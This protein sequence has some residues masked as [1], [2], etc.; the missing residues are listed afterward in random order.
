MQK[1]IAIIKQNETGLTVANLQDA[2]FAM[3]K[4]GYISPM[5]AGERPTEKDLQKLAEKLKDEQAQS[6]YGE[7]TTQLVFYFQLQNGLGDSLKGQ[8][9]DEKTADMI[10]RFLAE[11]GL[12]DQPGIFT[13][14]GAVKD[15][16]DKPQPDLTVIAF[17]KD[18][19]KEQALGQSLTDAQGNYRVE[20]TA[21]DFAIAEGVADKP[22]LLVRVYSD[23][24]KTT[25][26]AESET[27]FNAGRDEVFD[28]TIV[29][30]SIS[31]WERITSAVLPL[32]ENQREDGKSLPPNELTS[33][34]ID[35]IVANTGLDREQLRLW[36]LAFS[37]ALSTLKQGSPNV[38]TAM[39][40][41]HVSP[42]HPSM[43]PTKISPIYVIFYGWF[44]D[45][46]PQNWVDLIKISVDQL[47]A[48][49]KHAV[50][51]NY[52][53]ELDEKQ[54][55]GIEAFIKQ[56]KLRQVIKP[57]TEGEP[58]S[59][60]DV[61]NT[62][63]ADW[64]K[65]KLEHI[66][67]LTTITS[68]KSEDFVEQA[69]SAGLNNAQALQLRQTLYLGEITQNNIPLMRALQPKVA[70][71]K[72]GSLKGLASLTPNDWL[73]L[74]YENGVGSI[75]LISHARYAENLQDSIEKLMPHEVLKAK[76]DADS[77]KFLPL[78]FANVKTVLA[79]HKDFDIVNS[80][81]DQ[82]AED[83]KIDSKTTSALV[84]LQHL[85]RLHASWDEVSVLVNTK[86]DDAEEITNF[87][88]DQFKDILKDHLP[89]QRLDEI[90]RQASVLKA[91]S[92]GLVGHMFPVLYG[93]SPAVMADKSLKSHKSQIDSNPTLRKIFGAL[94]QCACD[95]CLS[96]LSPA[97]YLADLLK[98]IDGSPSARTELERRRPDIFDLELSC[99]NTKIEL[100]QIDLAIEILENAIALP[101]NVVWPSH[102]DIKSELSNGKPIGNNTL[103]ALQETSKE[104]L[105]N[106]V[107]KESA[108]YSNTL[109]SPGKANWTVDDQYRT[110]SIES[111]E[112]TL[113]FKKLAQ[114]IA[115]DIKKMVNADPVSELNSG[116]I[117][118]GLEGEVGAILGDVIG[119]KLPL[120]Q[121]DIDKIEIIPL[122]PASKNNLKKWKIN[123]SLEGEIYIDLQ[124]NSLTI[125]RLDGLD[126]KKS[127]TLNLLTE[128]KADLDNNQITSLFIDYLNNITRAKK[129]KINEFRVTTKDLNLWGFK[130]SGSIGL[131]YQ[132]AEIN[133]TGLAYQST[134]ADRDLFAKPQNTNPLAYK[135]I[136]AEDA[137]FPWSLPYNQALNETRETLNAAGVTRL[138]LLES[139]TPYEKQYSSMEIAKERLG[140]STAELALITTSQL[141]INNEANDKFFKVWGL[142]A[143][144]TAQ[145]IKDT[146]SDELIEKPAFGDEGLLTQVSI[147]LQQSGLSF[148]E[149]GRLLESEFINPGALIS[150]TEASSAN[151]RPSEMRLNKT[152]EN[153]LAPFLDRLHR[154]VRLW[155]VVG[156]QIWELDLAMQAEGIGK[157][158]LDDAAI[159]QIAN[160]NLLKERLHL[161]VDVLVAMIAGFGDK[162]Y[163]QL[164]KNEIRE[165]APLYDRLF[166]NRQLFDPPNP[167]LAFAASL[168]AMDEPLTELIAAS[169]GLR[170][171]EL[172][173]MLDSNA[174]DLPR[175]ILNGT[176]AAK[177]ELLQQVFRNV[178]LAKALGLSL[179]DYESAWQLFPSNHFESPA[180]LLN[181][182]NE[183]SFVKNS[184]FE[185]GELGYLLLDSTLNPSVTALELTTERADNILTVLQDELKQLLPLES[186]ALLLEQR[187]EIVVKHLVLA[188][189]LEPSLV[190]GLI[191]NY[192][193]S[194]ETTSE[195]AMQYL[196]SDLFINSDDVNKSSAYVILER[197]YK[198]AL[199][200]RKWGSRLSEFAWTTAEMAQ[201]YV[202]AGLVFNT[203][204]LVEMT[205][206]DEVN[207][208][209]QST[210][211]FQLAHSSPE[212]TALIANY[213]NAYQS[214]VI[215][216]DKKSEALLA[217]ATSFGLSEAT[218]EACVSKLGMADDQYLDPLCFSNLIGLL[219]TVHQL[220]I[221]DISL[222]NLVT[223]TAFDASAELAGKL[224]KTRF[225]DSGWQK[226]LRK[227][228]DAL[229]LQKRDRLVDFLLARE[230]LSDSDALYKHYLIDFEMSPCMN[231]TRMLQSTAAVQLFVQR[232]LFNLEQ[233]KV[234]LNP[235]DRKRWEWAQNYRVWEAN[236][237]VFLY[238]E[239]WLFPEVRDDK[240]ETF[241]AF[242]SALAQ[243]EPSHE[244]AV[245][246]L[247]Q[248]LDDLVEIGQISVVAMYNHE[249]KE[250]D[251][252]GLR[253]T[254]YLFGRVPN[255]AHSLFWCK[256]I[257]YGTPAENWTGWARVDAEVNS[258]YVI[259]FIYEGDLI[260]AWP[261]I[262]TYKESGN[263]I[264]EFF[265]ISMSWARKTS[266]G[267]LK[268]K[269]SPTKLPAKI[270]KPVDKT[271]KET[272]V[273]L[274]ND[275]ESQNSTHDLQK[276]VRIDIFALTPIGPPPEWKPPSS[277]AKLVPTA[278]NNISKVFWSL[279]YL[280]QGCNV[281]YT[282][283]RVHG[284]AVQRNQYQLMIAGVK[285]ETLADTIRISEGGGGRLDLVGKVFDDINKIIDDFA[286]TLTSDAAAALTALVFAQRAAIVLALL[287]P[288]IAYLLIIAIPNI[289][290]LAFPNLAKLIADYLNEPVYRVTGD[291]EDWHYLNQDEIA[292]PTN[293]MI[294][295]GQG[296]ESKRIGIKAF[297]FDNKEPIPIDNNFNLPNGVDAGKAFRIDLSILFT[298]T[299]NNQYKKPAV[300]LHMKSVGSFRF[301]SGIDDNWEAARFKNNQA[302]V[303]DPLRN[304]IFLANGYQENGPEVCGFLNP[305]YPEKMWVLP[306]QQPHTESALETWYVE[307]G[308]NK[309]IIRTEE[310]AFVNQLHPISYT[311]S[312]QYKTLESVSLDS[313]FDYPIATKAGHVW[314]GAESINLWIST[315]RFFNDPRD[316]P[317]LGFDL[318]NPNA[319]YNWEVFY[320]LPIAAA[321][322]LSRQH[323][324]E[325]ARQWFHFIFDPTTSDS[326]QGAQRFWRFLPFRSSQESANITELL[327]ALAGK[328]GANSLEQSVKSQVAA[329]MEDPFNPFAV[330]RLRNSAFEW[331]AVISYIKNLT[332][333][334]DQLFRRDT[335]ESINEATLLYIM[336]A[337]I[338]GPRPEKIRSCKNINLPMSYKELRAQKG[339]LDEFS[340]V[341][342]A[343]S[344]S[345]LVKAWIQFLEWLA[346]HGINPNLT[347][348][349]LNQL[350]SIGSLYFN[351]PP[352]EKLPELWDMVDDR[353]F[354]I[355]NCQNINGV[356]RSLPL[357]EPP[358]D[359]ELLIRAKAAG[360]DLSEVL[361]NRF[362]PLPQYRFQVLL[363]K[364]NEFCNEVK[365][366]GNSILSATEKKE[367]EHLALLR[368]SQEIDMLKL[369]ESVK[370]EQIK[371]AEANID[372]LNKTRNNALERFVFLQRQLGKN[373]L[374][375]DANGSPIVE[376][377][378]ITRVQETGTPNDTRSL[379]LINSEVDQLWKMQAAHD[380]GMISSILKIAG[381]A[382]HTV[383]AVAEPTGTTYRVA[384]AIGN[385][386]STVADGIGMISSINS[387]LERRSSIIGGWQRRRDEW[388]QQSKMTAE[389]IRQ[390]DKQIVALEIR[391][392]IAEKELDN[393]RK[394]IENA[395]NIDEYMRQM[396]F[397][398]ESMYGWME[399]Q[400][401][402]LYFSA[403]QMANDLAKKAER[404]Y[405][406]E[407][408]E[409][410][411]NFVQYGH[412]DSLRKGLLSGE[413]LSQN[414]RRMETAYFERNK[415][416][417]EITK[418]ISLRQLDPLALISLRDAAECEFHI[419]EI[420]FDLDFP[421]HYFRRI[422]SVSISVPC[423]V[424]PYTSVNGTLT[425]LSSKLRVKPNYSNEDSLQASYLPIQS[426]ATSGAQNDSGVFELNFRDER[427][428]PFEG[429]GVI[430]R[431]SFRLPKEFRQFD[432]NT[433]SDVILHI[434]YTARDGG[435]QLQNEV[436]Q[437]IGALMS[438]SS[439]ELR[440]P[441]LLNCSS[442]FS[443]EWAKAKA[444][445]KEKLEVPIKLDLLPY[446]MRAA[447]LVVR[448]LRYRL[449]SKQKPE[450]EFKDLQ[451]KSGDNLI[452]FEV[453]EKDGEKVADL[454]LV[455]DDANNMIVL[456]LVGK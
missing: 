125:S 329:W 346:Q 368:S 372:V 299:K 369:I 432:Y 358:I 41:T 170:K 111:L 26:I 199:L 115:L 127:T 345:P 218:V 2:L 277:S 166:Q 231:T 304:T 263:E 202:F 237:K 332:D 31:E 47:M 434:R 401:S 70:D 422:K 7:I 302:Q 383:G 76:L 109:S 241:K 21:K 97:A 143:I 22:D 96:V 51:Q 282:E 16:N 266:R 146:F 441:V 389:E 94:D 326:V 208:W 188:T 75:G 68:H 395:Q 186:E 283:P 285:K 104:K 58:A 410:T 132:P 435:G 291:L 210:T 324:F 456:L 133:I 213:L 59:F 353:L 387:Y 139:T 411:S 122:D 189:S 362:A 78:N 448:G 264:D 17:D 444:N 245:A 363:Q 80:N 185:W 350:S 228:N 433:I 347:W 390:I 386:L 211:L 163:R 279:D 99:D 35:F 330:A 137:C 140:L 54:L 83:N 420:L 262:K 286:N 162:R 257:N 276:S 197:L 300:P 27:R 249:E 294:A 252:Q 429:G 327:E 260:V 315:R 57:A 63:K 312:L 128:F 168:S 409:P 100:P 175:T 367:A 404:A 289:I 153:E 10:N 236:R 29:A 316:N 182:L 232:C 270:E 298:V 384:N 42:T 449:S 344:D 331:S 339:E 322:H 20:Y 84:K 195:S 278:S 453:L 184:G 319:N 242:E 230:G 451:V 183:Q 151:C 53:P 217:L 375:F 235:I 251:G 102:T 254:L 134:A 307:E 256:A 445:S 67:D 114:T 427:Y 265:E 220:G 238:P 108:P 206:Q 248:Y 37:V 342:L 214:T 3:V 149:F 154:F 187:A 377:S 253:N 436:T 191:E 95:P 103:K 234:T 179:H 167:G 440:F 64:V 90:Y 5:P 405:Q 152:S 317:D 385:G 421:G 205:S 336:A 442:D 364:A 117:P 439:E 161:P 301:Q 305:S 333:W 381:G 131:E 145:K 293:R 61:L 107:A 43:D 81:I 8:T 447:G 295:Y 177:N 164:I 6:V 382:A 269:T 91:T 419:P 240:T 23:K 378:L 425:L 454:G 365:N 194:E 290:A 65:G 412:W 30:Q 36:V 46:Q 60:G 308:N 135:T 414:L 357:Y 415:R 258:E 227:I 318:T 181:F 89:E 323:R 24:D 25:L 49:L 222:A 32:L 394:Q 85:K 101:F 38:E 1:I 82:F 200:N 120:G 325:D 124:D 244:N 354:K 288:P 198:V 366:L 4:H 15:S 203:L 196:T 297:G 13:I 93:V 55:I 158:N 280:V 219:R 450:A 359:P 45:G 72:Q 343:L 437:S 380:F 174:I 92:I 430:S 438:S 250:K 379:S 113:V 110:W 178:T 225:G 406:F 176:Q 150:I 19:R 335:R 314:F 292:I 360:L 349:Q 376:Q 116:N 159:T 413:R 428:L 9:V 33:T 268:H 306:A 88:K 392:S 129:Y 296:N 119:L 130:Y 204:Q 284:Y 455:P 340:N 157:Q 374:T 246:S 223:D 48:S 391:K 136:A 303:I 370:Q 142:Q 144:K 18:L 74:T 452:D 69:V 243:S 426:I 148:A 403:Y 373:E 287:N 310:R 313:L 71:D 215:V 341:W 50:T 274:L 73:N 418:H 371:E 172:V 328:A 207:N 169:V 62:M 221:D 12:L 393:H 40:R 123:F 77:I 86:I 337:E 87:G 171:T 351:V 271:I 400:I 66:V 423:V 180:T 338:L 417:L 255:E 192:L 446:W 233:S 173:F 112:E 348:E 352:N 397:A 229:R 388:V 106:L 121:S 267:W 399:S 190:K 239:N 14:R 311:E 334:A 155:R 138:S 212:M 247:K 361:E 126:Y 408:G 56:L 224:L 309:L 398:N 443:S 216:D 201:S 402:G 105:T 273:F 226:G 147:L 118:A 11:L 281:T 193:Y 320:H 209:K 52:I 44:R 355:R 34:D 259:P 275:I 165:I 321:V 28:F 39:M 261:N 424:G 396:K 79:K 272:F 416:E 407:L 156:W 98:F 431:W 160:L 141:K 356:R